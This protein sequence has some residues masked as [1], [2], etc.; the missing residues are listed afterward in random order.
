ME[1]QFK[2]VFHGSNWI[3]ETKPA[4]MEQNKSNIEESIENF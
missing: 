2:R 3:Y 1:K 4:M